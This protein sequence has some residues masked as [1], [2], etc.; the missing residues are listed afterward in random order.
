MWLCVGER[1]GGIIPT[2]CVTSPQ[3][4]SLS[5]RNRN[6][7][8]APAG[9]LFCSRKPDRPPLAR[10]VT[11]ELGRDDRDEH[12]LV[13]PGVVDLV[14]LAGDDE[15]ARIGLERML[16]PVEEQRPPPRRHVEELLPVSRSTAAPDRPGAYRTTR[17]TSSSHPHDASI[18]TRSS[19]PLPFAG[20]RSATLVT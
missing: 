5:T 3:P 6:S 16:A 9:S 8:S 4:T 15:D 10:G 18:V 12:Q 13:G 1:P 14:R 20:R 19:T 17:C 7:R 2:N 11:R